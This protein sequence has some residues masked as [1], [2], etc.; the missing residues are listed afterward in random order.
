MPK[1][2]NSETPVT[3]A[4][5]A[6]VPLGMVRVWDPLLRLFHWSLVLSFGLAWFTSHRSDSIHHWAGYGALS[7]VLIRLVWGILGPRHARFS[8]FLRRPGVIISYLLEIWRGS[9]ARHIGHNPAGGAMVVTL[10]VVILATAITGWVE[11][12][13]AY[14]G[15]RW[16]EE[17]HSLLAHGLLILVGVHIAGVALASYRHRENLVAAMVTGRKRAAGPE[18]VD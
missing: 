5:N 14:F 8:H 17:L 10:I 18:T 16:V 7:L 6:P 4:R 15:V 13:N 9:E 2:G 3:S 12:T 1:P 11:T